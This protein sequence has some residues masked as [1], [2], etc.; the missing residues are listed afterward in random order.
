MA[1]FK[2]L[3]EWQKAHQVTLEI[4]RVTGRF[5]QRNCNG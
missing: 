4:Y 2:P 5:P 3:K 1:D